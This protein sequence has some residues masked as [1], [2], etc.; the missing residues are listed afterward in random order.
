MNGGKPYVESFLYNING[1]IIPTLMYPGDSDADGS[2][3]FENVVR[4]IDYDGFEALQ[5]ANTIYMHLDGGWSSTTDYYYN[6]I[7]GSIED[8]EASLMDYGMSDLD[9]GRPATDYGIVDYM[10]EAWF[11]EYDLEGGKPDRMT[12]TGV[13]KPGKWN[14][15]TYARPYEIIDIDLDGGPAEDSEYYK[16]YNTLGLYD[17]DP[18][19]LIEWDGGPYNGSK[20]SLHLEELKYHQIS[21]YHL[22]TDGEKYLTYYEPDAQYID[23]DA[24]GVEDRTSSDPVTEGYTDRA[25][26]RFV[27]AQKNKMVD[28]MGEKYDSYTAAEE[29]E[30][31]ARTYLNT[32]LRWNK[33]KFNPKKMQFEVDQPD[34]V[35]TR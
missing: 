31:I 6:V 17:I 11:A 9:A 34:L 1:G 26:K 23:L 21:V 10:D 20:L 28:Q 5:L 27:K 2:T 7:S 16:E 3:S 15:E 25:I 32:R 18:I 13:Y 19:D 8:A 33:T 24:G 4:S 35:R 12:I 14:T 30:T 22:D 29:A